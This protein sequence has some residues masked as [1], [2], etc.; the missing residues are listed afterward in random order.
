MRTIHFVRDIL[1]AGFHMVDVSETTFAKS[2]IN[3]C[4]WRIKSE[5]CNWN[6]SHRSLVLNKNKRNLKTKI[7]RN[8]TRNFITPLNRAESKLGKAIRLD[9]FPSVRIAIKFSS[10]FLKLNFYCIFCFFF[11]HRVVQPTNPFGIVHV[12]KVSFL[13][14]VCSNQLPTQVGQHHTFP[15]KPTW[16]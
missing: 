16:C 5:F 2:F 4:V 3:E 6:Y 10:I 13:G 8:L 12:V 9:R 11:R 14:F 1:L 7:S 15:C